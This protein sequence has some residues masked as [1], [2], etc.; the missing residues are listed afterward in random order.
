MTDAQYKDIVKLALDMRHQAY[1]PYSHFQVGAGLLCKNGHIYKG[2]NIEVSSFTPTS[3]AERTAIFKAVSEG[4]RE[5]EAIAIAAGF[6]TGEPTDFCPPCGVCREVM[7]EFCDKDFKILLVKSET[8]VK[9]VSL[10]EMLPF[11]FTSMKESV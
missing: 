5:F 9:E 10:A 2:C 7:N 3:C 11:S 6:D 4:E 1:A 8:E